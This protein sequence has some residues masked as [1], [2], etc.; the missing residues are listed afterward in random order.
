MFEHVR[1]KTIERPTEDPKMREREGKR[2]KK[3]KQT[4]KQITETKANLN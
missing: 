4:N 2:E 1:Y 3:K